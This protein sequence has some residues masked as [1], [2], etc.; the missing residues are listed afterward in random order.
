MP[1]ACCIRLPP[2]HHA[3]AADVEIHL[4]HDDGR[5]F[6]ARGNGGR[7]PAGAGADDDDIRFAVPGNGV[8]GARRLRW[9]CGNNGA[10]GRARCQKASPAQR[11]RV[12]VMCL[13]QTVLSRWLGHVSLPRNRRL[14]FVG[15]AGSL[16]AGGSAYNR[17]S[18]AC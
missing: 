5:A 6:L 17:A 16:R 8:G 15:V 2:P 9:R 10:G 12:G 13:L 11:R 14:F 7:Q 3:A 18:V 1:A 4:D